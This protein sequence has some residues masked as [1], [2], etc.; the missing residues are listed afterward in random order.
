MSRYSTWHD[1]ISIEMAK[2]GEG[3]QDVVSSTLSGID[4]IHCFDAS[5]G[6]V[7]GVPFTV[8]T[9][10]RVYF[11]TE[12]DGSEDVASV[13]RNPDGKPTEHI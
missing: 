4:R 10:Q 3:W 13:S 7:E 11:A 5:F 9:T 12:Y 8:W 6:G 1:M 2:H